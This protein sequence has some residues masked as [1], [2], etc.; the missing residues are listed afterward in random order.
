MSPFDHIGSAIQRAA[1]DAQQ[2]PLGQNVVG[3]INSFRSKLG[4]PA[5][6]KKRIMCRSSRIIVPPRDER[7]AAI[8]PGDSIAEQVILDDIR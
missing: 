8:L 5:A 3:A 1:S 2:S 4:N 7:F 6:N